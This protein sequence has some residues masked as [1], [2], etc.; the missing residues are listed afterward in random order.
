M[1]SLH[2]LMVSDC[3]IVENDTLDADTLEVLADAVAKQV[4]VDDFDNLSLLSELLDRD[5][6]IIFHSDCLGFR[7]I[8]RDSGDLSDLSLGIIEDNL[9]SNLLGIGTSHLDT[10]LEN[11]VAFSNYTPVV[12]EI[13][14]KFVGRLSNSLIVGESGGS[15]EQYLLAIEIDAI[16]QIIL[17][18]HIA[19]EVEGKDAE[20][21]LDERNGR[22]L[23]NPVNI[24]DELRSDRV[25]VFSIL[26]L[27]TGLG[28][29]KIGLVV[30]NV[31]I[32][33]IATLYKKAQRSVADQG[34][35]A[36]SLIDIEDQRLI[37]DMIL[38]HEILCTLGISHHILEI[39]DALLLD[40]S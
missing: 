26:D 34:E 38:G 13:E 22:A 8:S 9:D 12:G 2:D 4:M 15:L 27:E 7:I 1:E 29:N 17:I 10:M 32:G 18:K 31:I 33:I 36:G 35:S 37:G 3:A 30:V 21:D 25:K 5:H 28:E 16:S 6:R 19:I 40:P 11:I 24:I 23:E 20:L 14:G 39:L